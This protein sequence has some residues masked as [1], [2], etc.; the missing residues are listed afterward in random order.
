MLILKI[1]KLEIFF[2]LFLVSTGKSSTV[3]LRKKPCWVQRNKT[4][5]V[6]YTLSFKLESIATLL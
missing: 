5:S 4:F 6:P 3:L 2:S 1:I